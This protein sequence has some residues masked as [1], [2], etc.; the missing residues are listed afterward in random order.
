M[1]YWIF[2][3]LFKKEVEFMKLACSYLSSLD[4]EKTIREFNL[5][6]CDYIHLDVMDGKFVNNQTLE[7]NKLKYFFEDNKKPLDIHLMVRDVKL[8]TDLYSLLNPEF[9]TFHLEIGDTLE[10]INYVKEKGI[11]VGLSIKPE[12]KVNQLIP[13]INLI[14][15]VLIMS[16]EP[17]NGGQEFNYSVL[18]KIEE[19][20]NLNKRITI[21]IDGGINKNNLHLIN[22]DIIVV[23]SYITNGDCIKLIDDLKTES[24]NL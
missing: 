20:R 5:S 15:M 12:T 11:K 14:D 8:Y 24:M 21:S 13:Y 7:Y 1:F 10:L 2:N 16:V 22:T 19:V 23:G 17:G 6:G 3:I 18:S 4:K 9:I